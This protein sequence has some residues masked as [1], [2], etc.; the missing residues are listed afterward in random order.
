MTKLQIAIQRA[1][2]ALKVYVWAKIKDSLS[3]LYL[4]SVLSDCARMDLQPDHKFAGS[5]FTISAPWSTPVTEPDVVNKR[6]KP[7]H[8]NCSL[9]T[10][11]PHMFVPSFMFILRE[12][13]WF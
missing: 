2:V 11:K 6:E 3:H 8:Q 5:D 9:L 10:A 7:H 4:E 12:N 1:W 13:V